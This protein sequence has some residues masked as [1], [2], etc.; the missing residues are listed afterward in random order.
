MRTWPCVVESGSRRP[1]IILLIPDQLLH[2]AGAIEFLGVII[3]TNSGSAVKT[4]RV[5]S[6]HS[7][8]VP[9]VLR[10]IG[11]VRCDCYVA[12]HRDIFTIQASWQPNTGTIRYIILSFLLQQPIGSDIEDAALYIALE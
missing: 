7:V 12:D 3:E 5:H 9:I 1:S 4:G 8:A 10:V 11:I 2:P 6:C